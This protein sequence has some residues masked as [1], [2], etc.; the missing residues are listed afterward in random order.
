MESDQTFPHGRLDQTPQPCLTPT[1]KPRLNSKH[2]HPG[3]DR[4]PPV[5][6]LPLLDLLLREIDGLYLLVTARDF[7]SLI[8]SDEFKGRLRKQ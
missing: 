7:R 2:Q 4:I 8:S 6:C 5:A 3:P 1:S